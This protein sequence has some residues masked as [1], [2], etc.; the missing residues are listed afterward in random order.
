MIKISMAGLFALIFGT[1]ACAQNLSVQSSP[2]TRLSSTR[3]SSPP[4][5]LSEIITTEFKKDLGQEQ[6][7]EFVRTEITFENWDELTNRAQPLVY[8]DL[9][10]VLRTR[11]QGSSIVLYHWWLPVSDLANSYDEPKLIDAAYD[12]STTVLVFNQFGFAWGYIGIPNTEGIWRNESPKTGF[13]R[14]G[15]GSLGPETKSASASISPTGGVEITLIYADGVHRRFCL[16][17]NG[18]SHWEEVSVDS[19]TTQIA[20]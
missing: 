13:R 7:L 12:G 3:A 6:M 8:H 15:E 16:E 20:R 5:Q 1:F 4:R 2:V 19:E 10:L 9:K 11:D 14:R 17:K 18:D